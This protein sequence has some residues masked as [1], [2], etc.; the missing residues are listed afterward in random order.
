MAYVVNIDSIKPAN[1]NW[2]H[3]YDP[4]AHTRD[5]NWVKAQAG[6]VDYQVQVLDSNANRATL[7]FVEKQNYDAMMQ[8]R[9]QQPDFVA[10]MTYR[11]MHGIVSSASAV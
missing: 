1:V 6:F 9:L 11:N 7:I 4:A 5:I 10:R 3:E 8:A 2:F